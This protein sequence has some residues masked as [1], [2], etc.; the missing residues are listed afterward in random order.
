MDATFVFFDEKEKTEKFN[1]S[2]ELVKAT[3]YSSLKLAHLVGMMNA[4]QGEEAE[5]AKNAIVLMFGEQIMKEIESDVN[6]F[7][8]KIANE[9][10]SKLVSLTSYIIENQGKIKTYNVDEVLLGLLFDSEEKDDINED[11]IEGLLDKL[12]LSSKIV[13]A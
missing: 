13:P 6:E 10:S 4:L 11:E 7:F 3:I 8:I 12:S 5:K 9:I 2:V 1:K